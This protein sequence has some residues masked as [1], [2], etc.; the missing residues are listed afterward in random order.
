MIQE[1]KLILKEVNGK[2]GENFTGLGLLVC[3]NA[4]QL[5]IAPLYATS[6]DLFGNDLQENLLNLSN[7][8]NP[9]HDGFHIISS[10]LEITHV[11]Q[12]FYPSPSKNLYLDFK[13]KYGARYYAARAGSVIPHVKYAAIVSNSYNAVVFKNGEELHK[14]H[15]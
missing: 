15:D 14:F 13:K 12:Y 2:A 5:P 9:Y 11:A 4:D 3:D 1:L 8:D 7:V 6:P 10:E